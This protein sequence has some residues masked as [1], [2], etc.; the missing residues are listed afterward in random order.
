LLPVHVL[1][2]GWRFAGVHLVYGLVLS[3]LLVELLLWNFEKIPFTCSYLPGKANVKGF[4]PLYLGAYWIYAHFMAN[5]EYRL[6]DRPAGFAL[7]VLSVAAATAIL[8]WFRQ[9]QLG[10]EFRFLF[11]DLPDPAVRTLNITH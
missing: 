6:L 10:P 2:W 1:L 9:R 5:I 11:E 7:F 3:V 4:W 8:R